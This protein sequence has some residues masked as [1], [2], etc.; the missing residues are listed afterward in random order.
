[1][2]KLTL[3]SVKVSAVLLLTAVVV[4]EVFGDDMLPSRFYIPEA[5]QPEG[6]PKPGKVGEIVVKSYPEYR[7]AVVT[8]QDADQDEMFQ[9]LFRHIKTNDIKM[10]APVEMTYDGGGE[11]SMAFLYATTDVGQTGENGRVNVLDVPAATVISIAVRGDYTKANFQANVTRLQ[12]WLAEN[13]KWE[14]VGPPRYFGYN[15]PF[16]PKALRYGEVQIPIKKS[17]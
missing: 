15:S 12:Q 17:S 1:M 6:F 16:V 9:T 14:T 11:K 13:G 7:A 3:R 8:R 5:R 10:T 2:A 4:L